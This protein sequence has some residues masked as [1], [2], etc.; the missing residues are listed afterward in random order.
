M[1]VAVKFIKSLMLRTMI[2]ET[3]IYETFWLSQLFRGN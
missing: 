3:I 1:K 2:P